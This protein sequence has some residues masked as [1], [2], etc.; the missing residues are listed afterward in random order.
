MPHIPSAFPLDLFGFE[1]YTFLA[2][3]G[4]TFHPFSI[5]LRILK[6]DKAKTL[7]N[8]IPFQRANQRTYQAS[9][10]FNPLSIVISSLL[11]GLIRYNNPV[12]NTR[13]IAPERP[14]KMRLVG[15]HKIPG[16]AASV[17]AKRK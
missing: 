5:R 8:P 15:C 7:P 13:K 17:K 14:N 12:H 16:N 11:N 3:G 9:R 2:G 1:T 6:L 4:W 10:P